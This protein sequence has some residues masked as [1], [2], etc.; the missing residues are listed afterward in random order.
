MPVG[1]PMLFD[2]VRWL[3]NPGNQ[4]ALDELVLT[5]DDLQIA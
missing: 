1:L 2:M 5:S 3:L 4:P